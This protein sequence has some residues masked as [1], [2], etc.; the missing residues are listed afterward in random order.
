MERILITGGAGFIGSHLCV[1][2]LASGYNV[3]VLDNLSCQVH[4]P[5]RKIPAYLSPDVELIVDDVRNSDAVR[6]ALRGVDAVF[7]FV[8][9]LG[10]GQSMYQ[11][12]HYTSVNNY[13]TA[14]LLEALVKQPI[15][16][17]V[18]ASSMS[19]Y[20]EGLYQGPGGKVYSQVERTREQLTRNEWEL[21][22]PQGEVLK[23]IA[24]PE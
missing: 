8:A 4:G 15:Q 19:L 14:V 11:L 18:V 3:R 16:R 24:T 7:H 21:H 2:L 13:G 17:L 10:V 12:A 5:D 22:S 23:P 1:E 9:V 20:G 6:K